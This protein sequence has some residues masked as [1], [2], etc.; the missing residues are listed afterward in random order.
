MSET[1]V[2]GT[3][4]AGA[5][6]EFGG[7]PTRLMVMGMAKRDG[8]IATADLVP[9]MEACGLSTDQ[10][11]SCLRRLVNEGLFTRDG[12]GREAIYKA[13]EAGLAVLRSNSDRT[14]LAYAQD[15]A[16]RGWDRQWRI[17]AFAIP[18]S[19]RSARDTFRDRLLSLGAASVHNGLYVSPHRW[20]AEVAAEM[21]R[22][23]IAQYVTTATTDDLEVGGI[24]NARELAAALWPL[25]DIADRYREFIDMY[26]DVPANLSDMRRRGEKI[27]EHDFLPGALHIAI[28]FMRCFELDPLLPPELLPKAWPGREARDIMARC[29]RIGLLA[30]EDKGGPAMFQV[31]D[32]AISALP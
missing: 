28:R 23:E 9:V 22:L 21:S 2:P 7:I 3:T 8:S 27:A 17:V 29:R 18:E 16:G 20:E 10:V 11:R 12:E 30:R 32:E 4:T 15:A 19:M 5:P 31:Y 1:T 13:T 25:D 6:D 26:H 24:T 14:V